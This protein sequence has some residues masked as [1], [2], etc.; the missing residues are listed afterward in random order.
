[1]GLADVG[2]GDAGVLFST[3]AAAA[4]DPRNRGRAR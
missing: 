1:M 2:A 4:K 3:K